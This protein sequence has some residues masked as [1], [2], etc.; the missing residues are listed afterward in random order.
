MINGTPK[1]F[2]PV[3]RELRR[4]DPFSPFLFLIVG[5]ALGRMIKGAA[6]AGLFEG[7]RVA[8]NTP[9]INHL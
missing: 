6:N 9:A 2:F 1:G 4:W 3:G 5:E 7:F 8:G